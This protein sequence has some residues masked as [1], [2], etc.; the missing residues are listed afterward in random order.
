MVKTCKDC[1][2]RAVRVEDGVVFTCRSTCKDYKIKKLEE[3]HQKSKRGK[4]N[5]IDS[6]FIE[7]I[8]KNR[9]KYR[10]KYG[11]QKEG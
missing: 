10:K 9:G 7:Q 11:S 6:A 2:D 1:P 4:Q 8:I 3:L 5:Q